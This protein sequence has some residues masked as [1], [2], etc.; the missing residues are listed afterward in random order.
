MAAVPLRL[1]FRLLAVGAF[2]PVLCGCGG[3]KDTKV[4]RQI[5]DYIKANQRYNEVVKDM[6]YDAELKT[7]N[8]RELGVEGVG[9]VAC[10]IDFQGAPGRRWAVDRKRNGKFE[11]RPCVRYS[12]DIDLAIYDPACFKE[13][14]GI[15][16]A[17]PYTGPPHG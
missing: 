17:S 3:Q 7:L 11:I 13:V 10:E 6:P 4:E 8:C 16:D 2:V 15:P 9:S 12:Y 1:V 5:R 14:P